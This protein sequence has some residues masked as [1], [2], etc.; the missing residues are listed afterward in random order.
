MFQTG[1]YGIIDAL[2]AGNSVLIKLDSRDP[3][4]EYLVGST[5]AEA[6]A[7]IQIISVDTK[8]NPNIGRKIIDG[9]DKVVFMGNPYKVIEIAYGEAMQQL[10]VSGGISVRYLSPFSLPNRQPV[11]DWASGS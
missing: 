10:G 1:A 7:P 8:T 6:G 2:R 3:Y 5:L 4:P 9:L 11:L